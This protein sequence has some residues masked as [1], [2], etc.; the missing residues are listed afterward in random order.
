MGDPNSLQLVQRGGRPV[1][2]LSI[3]IVNWNSKEF[4]RNCIESIVHN[5]RDT[6]YEIVVVDS[7]SF[8]GCGEMLASQYP[9][10]RFIQSQ[11]NI[12]FGRANN[13]GARNARGAVLLLL[14][15]DTEV[16]SDAIEHLYAHVLALPEAGVIGC[17]LLNTD[18][19]LQTSCVQ[20]IPTVSNQLLNAALLQ[21][22]FPKIHPWISA[23]TFEGTMPP[24]PVEVISG[25]CMMIRREVF[26]RIGG[27]SPDF[28][29]YG[30]DVDLC[31]KT[32]LA[33]FINY[34]M[35]HA[36]VVHHGG[37]STQRRH[38]HFSDVMVRESV[39]RFLR[40]SRGRPYCLAYRAALC[41]AAIVRLT[42]LALFL[43]P[44][45]IWRKDMAWRVA[46]D[47][48]AA[49]LRWGLGLESWVDDYASTGGAAPERQ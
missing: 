22:W 11:D 2:D 34:Y 45:L 12:G 49:S 18:G 16:R 46:T 28:F 27:F 31:Y 20:P 39:Y 41:G 17:R 4:V 23:A 36:E 6:R 14:N 13:L 3:I 21:R 44:A 7:A 8:D 30:E 1:V 29:M 40:K 38:S 42:L 19:T 37:G 48:W 26:D 9:Q 32:R 5:T 47:K 15:P 24:V 43:L 35:R 10:V 25:A 33:G